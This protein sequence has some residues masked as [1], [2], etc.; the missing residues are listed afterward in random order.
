M[1]RAEVAATP[2]LRQQG[3]SGHAP[4]QE[5]EGML[6]VYQEDE[7]G[8]QG[9]WMK[10]MLFPIDIIWIDTEGRVITIAKNI[11]PESYPEV[12]YPAR[13]AQYVLE[14]QAGFADAH[15]IA[16]GTKVVVE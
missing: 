10:D 14:V 2:A 1:V 7:D 11:Q 15:A 4:L 9:F 12:F 6:F 5:N 16:E 3:L 8:M 13:A